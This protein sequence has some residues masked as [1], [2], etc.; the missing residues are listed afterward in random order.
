MPHQ[1]G[2]RK[3]DERAERLGGVAA[4]QTA[5]EAALRDSESRPARP[6]RRRSTLAAIMTREPKGTIRF[7]SHGC[8]RLY[9]W[10]RDDAVGR[11]SHELLRTQFP[12]PLP[13]IEQ[14]LLTDGEWTGDPH[15]VQARRHADYRRRAQGAAAR[16]RGSAHRVMESLVD[17]T[18]LR[19]TEA[20]LQSLNRD[21]EHRVR[22]EVAMRE[23][24][25][26]RSAHAD[27]NPGA[28]PARRRDR[29]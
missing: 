15:P 29:A 4:K 9:G 2:L 12:I 17:V 22:D 23:A 8:E 21:L 27:R 25:Q 13:Q 19:Q 5:T 20:A 10:T 14:A 24:T 6:G 1:A 28:W 16:Q 26:Q 7:W 11:S 18:A 3:L